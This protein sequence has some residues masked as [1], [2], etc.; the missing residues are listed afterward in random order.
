[1]E[2]PKNPDESTIFQL[3]S[4]VGTPDEVASMRARFEQGGTGY[5]EFKKELFTRLWEF[6]GPMRQRREEILK[7][8]GYIDQILRKGAERANAIADRVMERVR[9]A[10]G[11]R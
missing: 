10:V 2:A 9:Q 3:F 6:F 5:G 8:P 4:L 11:L 1:V 7:D